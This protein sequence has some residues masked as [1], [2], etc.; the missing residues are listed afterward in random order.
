[1]STDDPSAATSQTRRR[2]VMPV[3]PR[4]DELVRNWSLMAA[5]AACRGA[6]QLRRF[7]L[8]LSGPPLKNIMDR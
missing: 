8:Q 5:I 2:R 7:A 4:E 3:D 6:D 1:M